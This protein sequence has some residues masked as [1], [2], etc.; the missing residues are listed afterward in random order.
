MNGWTPTIPLKTRLENLMAQV[1]QEYRNRVAVECAQDNPHDFER[2]LTAYVMDRAW[3][4]YPHPVDEAYQMEKGKDELVLYVEA[5]TQKEASI[6]IHAANRLPSLVRCYGK[7][8]FDTTW[9]WVF[10]PLKRENYR[11]DYFGNEKL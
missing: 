10:I 8:G 4:M 6:L 2:S 7:V 3:E 5:E 9:A 11:A 1:P